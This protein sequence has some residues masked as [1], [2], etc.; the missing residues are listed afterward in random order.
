MPPHRPYHC[1]IDLLPGTA[2]HRGHLCSLLAPENEA[3][4]KYISSSLVAGII[5]PSSS[6]AGAGVFF[7]DK[8]DKILRPCID[9]HGL[10]EITV[11]N[12]YFLPLISSALELLQGVKLFTK[13]DLRNA[14][15]LV[16]IRNGD[17]W[18][19]AFNTPT[20]HYKYLVMPFG[21]TNA[22]TVFQALVNDVLQD[23]L[24]Q[25]VFVYLDDIVIF[26]PDEEM[27]VQHVCQVLEHLLDNQLFVKAEKCEFHARTVSFLGFIVSGWILTRSVLSPIGS[28]PPAVSWSNSFWAS[29]TSTDDSFITSVVLP[30]RCM[31]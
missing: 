11:K 26:S 12:R 10:N 9:Y 5:H 2:P 16:R 8:K 31:R 23:M 6:P 20:G 18:K 25:F 4:E 30:L 3:M 1:T 24:N 28:R 29:P 15:H 19:T 13:L 14:N 17:E 22:P 7:V 21:L 27:H